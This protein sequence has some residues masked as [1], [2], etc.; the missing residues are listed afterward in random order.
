MEPEREAL[1]R[2]TRA[3]VADTSCHMPPGIDW[4]RLIRDAADN[5]V[6]PLVHRA[7]RDHPAIPP[8]AKAELAEASLANTA[9][10]LRLGSQLLATLDVLAAQGITALAYKGPALAVMAYGQPDLRCFSDLD[11]LVRREDIARA[12]STLEAAGFRCP[13][14][15]ADQDYFL[16]ERYHLH[17]TGGS[18][19]VDLELHWAITPAYWNFPL[20]STRLWKQPHQVTLFGTRLPTLDPELT[21]LAICAHGA[22]ERWPRLG[23]VCDLAAMIG[24]YRLDWDWIGRETARLHR[25]RLVGVGLL[26]AANLFESPIPPDL[27][28]RTQ[29]D[30]EA[31]SLAAEIE[32]H[33]LSGDLPRGWRFHRYA[34]RMWNHAADRRGYARY[35]AAG[36]PAKLRD[37]CQASPFRALW[38][39]RNPLRILRRIGDNL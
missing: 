2:A 23:S 5:A 28:R 38:R 32:E 10:A 22:K 24:R 37:L 25:E 19:P 34:W 12:Q 9:W 15:A 3:G 17:F 29:Q 8:E 27:L 11:I 4:T 26:L 39:Y 36:L 31:V 6:T 35:A 21:L 14:T 16:R 33:I 7:L 30:P 13:L 1:L 18:P 20:D